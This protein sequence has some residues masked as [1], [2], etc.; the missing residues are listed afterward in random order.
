MHR[1]GRIVTASVVSFAVVVGA[2]GW[3]Y[4]IQPHSALPGPAIGDALPLDEL[5]RRSAVPLL[6]FLAVA[7]AA[8]LLG[9]IARASRAER[10]TA[11]LMLG[12]GVGGWAYLQ[13]GSPVRAAAEPAR[14]RLV[15]RRCGDPRCARRGPP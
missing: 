1:A 8:L 9:L 13:T 3:L 15:C 5:S 11:G 14:A 6:V 10:L 2:G 4:V 7:A 12:L